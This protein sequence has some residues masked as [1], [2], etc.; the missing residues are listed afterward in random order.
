M[1]MLFKKNLG[2][3]Y[4]HLR[5]RYMLMKDAEGR[6][7]EA[8]MYMYIHTMYIYMYNVYTSGSWD[9]KKMHSL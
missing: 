7:K 9:P 4:V 5:V 8:S 2:T 6:K 1:G 3:V